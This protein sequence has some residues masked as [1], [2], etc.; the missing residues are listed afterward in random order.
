M[1]IAPRSEYGPSPP[2]P[3]LAQLA[4][5]AILAENHYCP[6]SLDLIRDYKHA[7]VPGCGHI[8]GP[9]AA[10]LTNCPVC[11]VKC[12]WRVVDVA[13]LVLA[14]TPSR[15]AIV[16]S[17]VSAVSTTASTAVATSSG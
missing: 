12:S 5:R 9:E 2:S 7:Y 3:F 6:V 8:C 10:H 4:V 16:T 1:N 13:G 15:A 17:S 11:R 14:A